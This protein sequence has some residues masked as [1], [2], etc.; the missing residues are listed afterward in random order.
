M[1]LI[2]ILNSLAAQPV[3]S[4]QVVPTVKH[5]DGLPNAVP[6]ALCPCRLF[7]SGSEEGRG[8]EGSFSALGTLLESTFQISDLMLWTTQA[9]GTGRAQYERDLTV[10][11]DNYLAM[12][13]GWRGAGQA[14]AHVVGFR[15]VIGLYEYPAQSGVRFWGVLV[16]VQ[17]QEFYST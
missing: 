15:S 4:G 2:A 3:A 7:L 17:V 12:L 16:V 9:Q 1:S 13:R 6:T 10:Y 8:T 14:Q 11:Q 5:L